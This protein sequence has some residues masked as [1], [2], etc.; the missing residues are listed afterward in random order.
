MMPLGSAMTGGS[1]NAKWQI[2]PLPIAS[3]VGLNSGGGGG[4]SVAGSTDWPANTKVCGTSADSTTTASIT[5]TRKKR[6][7]N[8]L[9]S[10][11][12]FIVPPILVQPVIIFPETRIG[13]Y[14]HTLANHLCPLVI[15][16]GTKSV[17]KWE[18]LFLN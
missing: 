3:Q 17:T 5:N 15:K 7:V 16:F 14:I 4:L 9:I 1:E 18:E 11:V 10:L 6:L 8:I 2:V 12:F 13:F